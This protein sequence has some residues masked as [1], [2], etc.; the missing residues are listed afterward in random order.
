MWYSTK[1]FLPCLN[2]S[3]KIWLILH[4]LVLVSTI[5]QI[6]GYFKSVFAG[7]S[8][9]AVAIG[10]VTLQFPLT[11]VE[12]KKVFSSLPE[13]TVKDMADFALFSLQEEQFYK[14]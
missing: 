14:F 4:Y 8:Y 10:R 9:F 2:G 5:L 7:S 6:L 13:W 12:S 1:Y 11:D 3:L